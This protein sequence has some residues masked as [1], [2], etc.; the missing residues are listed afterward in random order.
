MV[1]SSD[2]IDKASL[3]LVRSA[4]IA[5]R[6]TEFLRHY[7]FGARGILSS[8]DI[9]TQRQEAEDKKAG[10]SDRDRRNVPGLLKTSLIKQKNNIKTIQERNEIIEERFP[11]QK[12]LFGRLSTKRYL[13]FRGRSILPRPLY[14]QTDSLA[15]QIT[16]Y[17]NADAMTLG[18]RIF[19]TR[20]KF[21]LAN[22]RG[23][24][25]VVHELVHIAQRQLDPELERATIS[26]SKKS[27]LEEEARSIEKMFLDYKRIR[28]YYQR[29]SDLGGTLHGT[30]L[31]VSKLRKLGS[32][33]A[34]G[35][36]N[37]PDRSIKDPVVTKN[38]VI[39]DN[40]L[41]KRSS[42]SLIPKNSF[43]SNDFFS[44]Q[45]SLSMNDRDTSLYHK[46][47]YLAPEPVPL[48]TPQLPASTLTTTKTVS[49]N[50]MKAES[51][52]P[53]DTSAAIDT[54]I[55]GTN[56]PTATSMDLTGLADRVY[57]LILRKIKME[58]DRRG[59]K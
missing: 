29:F 43:P 19:I 21:N 1:D 39:A 31:I 6:L 41:S 30:N 17:H 56:Q 10:Q 20:N 57:D 7:G 25:L 37:I 34:Y 42:L 13:P 11:V 4:F 26:S 3:G 54:D 55:P 32:F 27:Y 22:P 15:N 5:N 14:M 59:L 47:H 36:A 45:S 44:L 9:N 18:N 52:R 12:Q 50:Y 40:K 51:S 58:K 16:R 49:A 8:L 35:S 48:V 23:Q 28:Y 24:A 38:Q 33:G 2:I 53:V 46:T